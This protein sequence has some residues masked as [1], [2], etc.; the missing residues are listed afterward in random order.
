MYQCCNIYINIFCDEND[1]LTIS[2]WLKSYFK[3]TK[4]CS[5]WT[6]PTNYI[7]IID[8]VKGLIILDLEIDVP[9]S[10]IGGYPGSR[11]EPPEPAYIDSYFDEIDFIEWIKEILPDR[12]NVEIE[13][14]KDSNIPTE[15]ELVRDF[16]EEEGYKCDLY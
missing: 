9:C 16:E 14:D 10:Y 3:D 8:D 6:V 12:F 1:K 2:E 4:N 13:I 5:I 15:E 11:W 7:D